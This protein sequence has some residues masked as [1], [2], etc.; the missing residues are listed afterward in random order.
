MVC[1]ALSNVVTLHLQR[2]LRHLVVF[3]KNLHQ[4][5]CGFNVSVTIFTQYNLLCCSCNALIISVKNKH[6]C[7]E[8]LSCLM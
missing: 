7:S 1:D 4:T 8:L 6:S 5:T 2:L 3:L